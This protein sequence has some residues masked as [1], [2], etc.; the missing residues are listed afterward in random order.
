MH[1][2]FSTMHRILLSA[3]DRFLLE[4]MVVMSFSPILLTLSGSKPANASLFRSVKSHLNI[5]YNTDKPVI[6]FYERDGKSILYV[7]QTLRMFV[8]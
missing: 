1:F 5:I 8:F 4:N 6:T 7:Y 2:A 3:R